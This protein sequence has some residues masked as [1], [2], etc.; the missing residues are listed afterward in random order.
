MPNPEPHGQRAPP[1]NRPTPQERDN[2]LPYLG[3]ELTLLRRLRVAV[4]LGSFAC[5]GMLRAARPGQKCYAAATV[6]PRRRGGGRPLCASGVLPPQPAEH[7]HREVDAGHAGRRT[8]A[9][10]RS[11]AR[12][13]I[14]G[15]GA[16]GQGPNP[17]HTGA[18]LPRPRGIAP[19]P[20]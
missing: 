10:D 2:C 5:D 12:G 9:G 20:T 13:L 7:L 19:D 3:E 16:C 1:D 8:G 4:C 6:Q 17:A 11:G 18:Q 14:G 15:R